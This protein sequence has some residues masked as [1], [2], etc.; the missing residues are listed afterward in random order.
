MIP[1]NRETIM[2]V[3]I[4]AC[5]ASSYYLYKENQKLTRFLSQIPLAPAR[6]TVVNKSQPRSKQPKAD[7][8]VP[9]TITEESDDE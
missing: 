2:M 3:A 6:D 9:E 5:L 4:V 7:V 1:I 8:V